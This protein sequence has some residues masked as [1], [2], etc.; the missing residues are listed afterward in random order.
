MAGQELIFIRSSWKMRQWSKVSN[1]G[2]VLDFTVPEG[3][4]HPANR[5]PITFT[6]SSRNS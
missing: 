1:E 4:P 3:I 5:E 2:F 6:G